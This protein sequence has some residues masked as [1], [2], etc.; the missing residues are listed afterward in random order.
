MGDPGGGE[1]A[2]SIDLAHLSPRS[3]RT[4][5]GG[6]DRASGLVL[7][8]SGN[9]H[10]LSRLECRTRTYAWR[11]H[12]GQA[13]IEFP[14]LFAHQYSH[15]WVDFRG[16]T[17][18]WLGGRGIDYFENSRRAT[19]AQQAYAISNPAGHPDYGAFVWGFT[20][21][22]GPDG[23]S[24][25]GAPPADHEDG[26]IAPTAVAASLPF[27]PEICLPTLRNFHERW[28]RELWTQYGFRDAFNV[29]SNW[30][31]TDVLGI[32]QGPILLMIENYRTGRV[33]ARMKES[34]VF[35]RGLTAAG[36]TP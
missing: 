8:L 2:R 17:D 19:L 28:G 6:S 9:G 14:H 10:L 36:F 31:A 1:K 16:I 20:A 29:R 5:W 35:R 33:W 12:Y 25:R 23:Y 22:D 26:T 13:Y 30:F 18:S 21:C 24:G 32:D 11:T 27:A 15:C 34:P 7:S 3:T 4:R